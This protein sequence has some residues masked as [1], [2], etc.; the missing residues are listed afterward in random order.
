[1]PD[2]STGPEVA[3]REVATGRRPLRVGLR[4]AV[5]QV[6]IGATRAYEIQDGSGRGLARISGPSTLHVSANA[7]AEVGFVLREPGQRSWKVGT[8]G[9][10]L[11]PDHGG[12]WKIGDDLFAGALEILRGADGTITVV[13]ETGMESYLEGVIPWE[14]GRPQ[15]D[16]F[17][18]VQAQAI[19]ARTYAYAHLGHWEDQGFDLRADVSDQVYRGRRGTS[20]ITD[21]AVRSTRGRVLV[22]GGRL[23]RAYYSSTCGGYSANL[24][25]VWHKD[26]ADYLQGG[27]DRFEGHSACS[28]SPQFRWREVWSAR[29]LGRIV[30]EHLPEEV[31]EP[32]DP[33]N[34]GV[35]QGVEVVRRDV[36]GRVQVLRI[37]TD[38]GDFEVWG[39]RIRWVL[40]PAS[41]R[42]GILRSTLFEIEEIRRE[43]RLVGVRV[44]G[45]GFGHGVGLC[46]TGALARARGGQGVREILEH[47]YPGVRVVDVESLDIASLALR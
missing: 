10:R 11:R 37:D 34:I 33:K 5:K 21:R 31:D 17:A 25:D 42:F 1:V 6:E 20:D 35:L 7:A 19:A 41:G 40:R 3:R 29:Q 32:I 23:I 28:A 24:V 13:E 26:G 15:A 47:Y 12:A 43:G 44:L 36:S 22:A 8:R 39:D 2:E 45:G 27:P 18:A 4:V 30:R 38:R 16:A 14:I 46:Q 9:L